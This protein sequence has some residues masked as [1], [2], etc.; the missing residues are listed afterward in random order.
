MIREPY[1]LPRI[2][3]QHYKAVRDLLDP[4]F[5]DTYD[6]WFQLFTKQ[7]L[8]YGQ[9]DYDVHEV[10]IDPHE[11]ARY[12]RATGMPANGRLLLDFAEEKGTGSR[13]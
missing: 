10:E 4:D 3:P 2:S 1:F 9:V 5:P 11:F 8:E 6:E 13:Y 7:K 12:L